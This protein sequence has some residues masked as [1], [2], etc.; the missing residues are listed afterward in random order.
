[1]RGRVAARPLADIADVA[2]QVFADKGFRPAGISD[3]AVALGL[4]HGALYTYVKSKQALLHLALLWALRPG[5]V[6]TLTIPVAAVSPHR[7]SELFDS[8]VADQAGLPILA[9]S[10]TRLSSRPVEQELGEIIDELYEFIDR[11]RQ[12]LKLVEWCAGELPE[13]A[14][15]YFVQRRRRTLE[16][17]G[18][19]LQ[20]RIDARRLR[21][22]PDVRAAA[23][24]LV[25]AIAWFAMHRHGDPDSTMLDDSTSR[26]T[27]RHLLMAAFVPAAQP[28]PITPRRPHI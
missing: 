22:V 3:V 26:N 21:P 13:L 28:G 14:Q 19:F 8:W 24:F 5:E 20:S 9:Q 18:E 15:L 25:E 2:C 12:V 27:V 6:D 17:L 16:Q 10:A 7:I 1:M 11:N 23:R 4:S